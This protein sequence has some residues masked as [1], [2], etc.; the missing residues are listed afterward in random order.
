MQAKEQ[1]YL[2]L[3]GP[4]EVRVLLRR[5]PRARRFSLRV[6]GLDGR[7]TLSLPKG[8]SMR[9]GV[10]FVRERED[11]IR[12]HLARAPDK[13]RPVFGTVIPFEGMDLTITPGSGRAPR[14]D[15]AQLRVPGDDT[16]LARRVESFLKLAAR[17]RLARASDHY[18]AQLGTPYNRITLRDTRS[19]W[20][21]CSTG[22][23]LMYSWRLI[24]APPSV[25]SYVAAHEVA[26]LAEM[27]HSPAYWRVLGG[28]YPD[29]AAQK[30]WLR[31]HG[32]SLHAWVFRD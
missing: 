32:H 30:A 21:S 5:S 15:G 9:A 27:N 13:V 25:L 7:V 17:D 24:M 22:A 19:R 4:P 18:A 6:S 1:T 23:N 12:S 14:I 31:E 20:G 10:A 3:P 26:H 29:Y 28:L 8:A 11:W 16:T 2:D